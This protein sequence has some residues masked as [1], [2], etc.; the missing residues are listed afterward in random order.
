MATSCVD[1]R[2]VIVVVGRRGGVDEAGDHQ[3][4]S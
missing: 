2:R 3:A 4:S 1:E